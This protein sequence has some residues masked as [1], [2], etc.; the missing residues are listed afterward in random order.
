VAKRAAADLE[1]RD[2]L[3]AATGGNIARS[4]A[5]DDVAPIKLALEVIPLERI[6]SSIRCKTDRKLYPKNEPATSWR[7][8]RRLKSIAQDY[9]SAV[10]VPKLVAA[11][12]AA[13]RA[14]G[15]S[16]GTL[17]ASA[18]PPAA[19]APGPPADVPEPPAA[20][21]APPEPE[22]APASS[23]PQS[24]AIPDDQSAIGV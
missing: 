24:A 23:P 11:W 18:A 17:A 9:C 1:L 7:E 21:S 12:E 20:V 5:L 15:K 19:P 4:S 13:G 2:R 22:N 14:P 16:I 3:I 6:L 10:I 8:R